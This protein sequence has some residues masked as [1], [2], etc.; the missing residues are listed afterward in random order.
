MLVELIEVVEGVE[1][2][3]V[4]E[5]VEDVELPEVITELVEVLLVVDDGVVPATFTVPVMYV[6][7]LQW[8][9]NVPAVAKVKLN[10]LPG[11]R[12]WSNEPSLAVTVW[13]TESWFVQVTVLF[14]PMTTVIE[15]GLN[16][17][18]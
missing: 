10:E 15:P 3:E 7:M 13:V 11:A 5:V 12:V 16:A 2:N 4:L 1:V 18:L 8:Y 17:K 9:P 14:T 6:W